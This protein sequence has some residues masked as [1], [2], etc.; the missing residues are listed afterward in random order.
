M[1]E[2]QINHALR[3]RY[4]CLQSDIDDESREPERLILDALQTGPCWL[5]SNNEYSRSITARFRLL[6]SGQI[7]KDPNGWRLSK[8]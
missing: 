3:Q 1:T 6:L 5:D 2:E 7:E 8:T 4:G